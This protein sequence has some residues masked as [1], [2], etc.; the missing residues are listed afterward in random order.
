[1]TLTKQ[2]QE[3]YTLTLLKEAGW[4]PNGK[5][6]CE[7]PVT[8]MPTGKG[9]NNGPGKV[10]YALWSDNEKPLAVVEAKR[11]VKDAR[12]GQHQA[13]LYADCLQQMHNHRPVIFFTNGFETWIGD[14]VEYAPRKVYGFYKKDE[15]ELLI[16]RRA[17][18]T[19]LQEAPIDAAIAD[20]YYQIEAI[21]SVGK[22]LEN[23]GREAL[24]IM[25]T[26]TGKTRTAA[27]LVDVL[28]KCN[29]VKR[30]L[31]L[32]DR[33][34]LIYQARKA[35]TN[36]L[37][38]LPSVDLTKD[39]DS[40]YARI[41]FSTYQTMINQIDDEFDNNERH[42]SIGHFDLVIFDEIHRS[43][44]SKYRAIF[45]YFDAYKIGLTATPKSDAD[46]DTY[47]LFRLQPGNPTYAYELE[48]A[49]ERKYLVPPQAFSVPIKFHR[50]GVK[51]S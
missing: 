10:D 19:S 49:V 33:T 29:W 7:Y 44:Y 45:E 22:V 34:A 1:L 26:G 17:T 3:K 23:R 15:L 20:R 16:Q 47:L 27:A 28:S 12:I 31:F 14:D 36:H 48:E 39:K 13:K 4:N 21:R 25:A 2:S 42:F 32:A 6:V 8:G 35:F 24:L 43:V 38:N 9:K 41:I 37:P 5:D 51:Y 50:E 30:V 46:R 40:G 11:T 18:R